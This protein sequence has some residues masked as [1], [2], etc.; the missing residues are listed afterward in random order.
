MTTASATDRPATAPAPGT[1]RPSTGSAGS[2]AYPLRTLRLHLA[3]RDHA[4]LA[5]V[6]LLCAVV[7]V[8]ILIGLILG[9]A[10]GFPLPEQVGEGFRTNN[11]GVIW[12]LTGFFISS[13]ALSVNRTFATVLA[14]GG[15]RRDYW[16]G[17]TT[18]F[19]ITSLITG[20]TAL[21]LLLI[22]N[23]TDG[24]VLGVH[25]ID[26]HLLGGGD[27]LRTFVTA[28]LFALSGLLMGAAFGT[29]FRAFGPKVLT[30]V[31]SG[32]GLVVIGL[33]ALAVWQWETT[34]QIAQG[35]GSWL[36]PLIMLVIVL[37]AGA[38]SLLAIRRASV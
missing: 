28:F 35:T 18:G 9:I 19:V 27:I 1:S 37:V 34:L 2:S 4:Y 14:L 21:M 29:V 26:V 30:L 24:Y 8:T 6:L 16:L 7:V 36:V 23:A 11:L 32:V 22:E 10:L 17:A 13:A 25:A 12:A 20:V 5:P 33:V 38:G 3:E 31:I 15:T